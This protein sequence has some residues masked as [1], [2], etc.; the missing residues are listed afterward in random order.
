MQN[1]QIHEEACDWFVRMRDGED[2]PSVRNELMAWLRRSPEHVDAYLDVAAIWM[3]MKNVAADSDVDLA[4]R[5]D[6][7]RAD[8]GVME[9]ARAAR[10]VSLAGRGGRRWAGLAASVAIVALAAV[11]AAWQMYGRQTYSTELGEQ[12][13]IAL[14]DGS[15]IDLNSLSRVRVRFNDARRRIDLL[16][17]QA[18]FHVAKDPA[19]PFVVHADETSVRALG[20]VFDVY[21]KQTS[22]VVTVV[23]G[24]VVVEQPESGSAVPEAALTGSA[25]PVRP[26]RVRLSAG[27]QLIVQPG[28]VPEPRPVNIAAATAWTQRMLVFEFTALAEVADEFNRYNARELVVEGEQLRTFKV[29]AV[30]RSTDPASLVSFLQTMPGIHITQAERA[31]IISADDAPSLSQP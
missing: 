29:S 31:I 22:A 9:L 4:T 11:G 21:R 15:T 10:P 30:F 18:L 14:A 24:T 28:S 16:R 2:D 20:T 1:Q 19:R 17:G 8:S 13:S 12:R 6:A 23:E 3:E 27:R 7:A 25:E 26:S 5:I